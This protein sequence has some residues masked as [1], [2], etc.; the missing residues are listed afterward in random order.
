M[1]VFYIKVLIKF[2][3][4]L[5]LLSKGHTSWAKVQMKKSISL[6]RSN[7]SLTMPN[8]YGRWGSPTQNADSFLS[9]SPLA[10]CCQTAS[11]RS[12]WGGQGTELYP[13]PELE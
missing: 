3:H 10:S 6:S 13:F 11:G 1:Y 8:S 7:P 5:L 9:Q 2:I 12:H 4:K